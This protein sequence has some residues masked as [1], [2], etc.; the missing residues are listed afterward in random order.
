MAIS[1]GSLRRH[2]PQALLGVV[3]TGLALAGLRF[4]LPFLFRPDEDVMVG[5]AVRMALEGTPDPGFYVYPPLAFDL[6]AGAERLLPLLPDGRLGAATMV[7]P[8]GEY[9]VGRVVSALAFVGAV[10]LTQR[11]A[12]RLH[13]A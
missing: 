8:S 6:F 2:L 3:A 11:A 4:G 13:G 10:L 1:T 12:Q 9:L 5:R 7:D